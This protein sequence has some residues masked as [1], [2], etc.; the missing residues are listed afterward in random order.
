MD[1]NKFLPITKLVINKLEGGYFHPN[2]RTA[3]PKV[4]G[5]YHRSGET[6]MGLDRHAGHGLYYSTPQKKGA[7]GKKIDVLSNLKNIENGSYKYLNNDAKDFWTIIDNAKAKTNWKWN[8]KG[9]PLEEK[10]TDLAS[11]I[12]YPQFVKNFNLYLKNPK[13]KEIVEND[14]RLLFHLIYAT[15]NGSGFFK[16]FATD[17]DNAV[18]KGI[19]D[20][21]KLADISIN[22]RTKEGLKAGSPPIA[23]IVQ[24]GNKIKEI[25]KTIGKTVIEKKKYSPLILIFIFAGAYY[26]YKKYK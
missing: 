5:S 18:N 13:S 14:P 12:M 23:L 19:T 26:I 17:I 21:N 16:K 10:L 9:G 3:N 24:G 22:S 4:F 1:L 25:F 6:M 8:Y 15:W 20:A 2:M 11:K 7:D